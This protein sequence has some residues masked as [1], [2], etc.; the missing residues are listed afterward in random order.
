MEENCKFSEE[1]VTIYQFFL[2]K[3]SLVP[4]FKWKIVSFKLLWYLDFTR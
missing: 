3:K 1:R 2:L 4:I